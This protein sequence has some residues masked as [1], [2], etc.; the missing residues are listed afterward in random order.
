MHRASGRQRNAEILCGFVADRPFP[1]SCADLWRIGHSLSGLYSVMGEKQVESV[2]WDF[3]KLPTDS[4]KSYVIDG[5]LKMCFKLFKCPIHWRM[6]LYSSLIVL[7]VFRRGLDTLTSNYRPFISRAE[8]IYSTVFSITDKPIPFDTERLN[9]GGAMN[10]RKVNGAPEWNLFIFSYRICAVSSFIGRL[11]W[12]RFVFEWRC[13]WMGT[14]WW[15]WHHFTI[16][17]VFLP[18]DTQLAKGRSEDEIWLEIYY[19]STGAYLWGCHYTHF[20]GYLLEEKIT[21]A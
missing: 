5:S 3:T 16:R 2:Y 13:D 8:K 6:E 15:Y 12:C 1:I 11:S 4:S 17:K 10:G 20:S 14:C 7:Q 9:V 18:I 21:V 19:K